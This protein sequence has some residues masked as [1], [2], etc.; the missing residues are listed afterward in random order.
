MTLSAKFAGTISMLA[1]LGLFLKT[2]RDDTPH[3]G[4]FSSGIAMI[5][6][7]FAA[8]I[9]QMAIS[10]TREYAADR[11]G[12]EICGNPL[13]LSLALEKL[14]YAARENVNLDAE[15]NTATAHMFIIH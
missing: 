14:A 1:N 5:I 2:E 11:R 7:P 9:V 3:S 6:A 10:R 12:A 4:T 8:F 15:N 13:W